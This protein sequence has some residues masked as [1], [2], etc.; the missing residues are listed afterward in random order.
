MAHRADD[1]ISLHPI[2]KA[3]NQNVQQGIYNAGLTYTQPR[4]PVWPSG[5]ALGW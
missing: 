4:E 5:K 2:V 1:V 3:D